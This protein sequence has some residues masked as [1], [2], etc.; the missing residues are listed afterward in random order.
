MS[1]DTG[2]LVPT[3]V[4]VD[5]PL[6]TEQLAWLRSVCN[7][8]VVSAV[9]AGASSEARWAIEAD[10]DQVLVPELRIA[11]EPTRI[12]SSDDSICELIDVALDTSGATPED[13]PYNELALS[14]ERDVQITSPVSI[15][16]SEIPGP[17]LLVVRVTGSPTSICPAQ[18]W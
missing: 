9:V 10:A 14:A 13:P 5:R 1:A 2:E 11:V 16:S 4:L 6:E 12:P 17:T 15:H 18:R 7:E 8:G 3:V